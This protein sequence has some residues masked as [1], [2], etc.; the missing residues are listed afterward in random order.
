MVMFFQNLN[1]EKWFYI[2]KMGTFFCQ[3]DPFKNM[4]NDFET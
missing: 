2:S 4:D 1:F 3:N